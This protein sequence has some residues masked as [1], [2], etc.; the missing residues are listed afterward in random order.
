MAKKKDN[1]SYYIGVIRDHDADKKDWHVRF[2]TSIDYE[3]GKMAHWDADKQP[4]EF[5]KSHA[6]DIVL[7]LILNG[8]GAFVVQRPCKLEFYFPKEETE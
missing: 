2:V 4:M 7:G 3:G 8:Y 6:E 5:S 1:N